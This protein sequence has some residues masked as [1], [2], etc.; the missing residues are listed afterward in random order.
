[1]VKNINYE[2]LSN[3][4]INAEKEII[5]LKN[6]LNDIKSENKVYKIDLGSIKNTHNQ[7]RKESLSISTKLMLLC[8]ETILE[9][10]EVHVFKKEECMFKNGI[11]LVNNECNMLKSTIRKDLGL[12]KT[13]RNKLYNTRKDTDAFKINSQNCKKKRVKVTAKKINVRSSILKLNRVININ[14]NEIRKYKPRN[15][16]LKMEIEINNNEIRK[17]I[18]RNEKCMDDLNKLVNLSNAEKTS[19]NN[20]NT[21]VQVNNDNSKVQVNEDNSKLKVNNTKVQVHND[22]VK[23]DKMR[24]NNDKV[25]VNNGK[26]QVNNDKVRVN[27]EN[28]KLKEDKNKAQV[29]N[30]KSIIIKNN[31]VV[32]QVNLIA[33]IRSDYLKNINEISEIMN[34]LHDDPQLRH[35]ES[36]KINVLTDK[37]LEHAS[38]MTHSG[39]REWY[40]VIN[41][42][43][44]INDKI[45]LDDR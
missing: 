37:S 7:Y 32:D 45:D 19:V 2:N 31:K 11:L 30:D 24:V 16:R 42:I 44:T 5:S 43:N 28:T 29:N 33:K 36:N 39:N 22:K 23:V 35:I 4:I 40:G 15:E 14:K 17:C 10:N 12:V 38:E 26:V 34:D 27:K 18:A 41:N 9:R 21:K 25:Q 13:A 8:D 3:R 1:M 6:D 20:D